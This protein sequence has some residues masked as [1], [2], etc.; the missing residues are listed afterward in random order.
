[1]KYSCINKPTEAVKETYYSNLHILNQLALN[2]KVKNNFGF[3]NFFKKPDRF[4]YRDIYLITY[5][6]TEN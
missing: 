5:L 2:M 4:I 3:S 1:M 6:Q